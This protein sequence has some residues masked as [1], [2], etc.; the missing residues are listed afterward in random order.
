M[1]RDAYSHLA[2]VGYRQFEPAA[3]LRPFVQCYW[4]IQ[5]DGRLHAVREEFLHPDGATGIMFHVGDTPFFN[6]EAST[7]TA[8]INGPQTVT[9]RLGLRG[10]VETIGVRFRPG[11]A[12]ALLG[13]PLHEVSGMHLALD[14]V[15]TRPQVR[16]VHEQLYHADTVAAKIGIVERWLLGLL[17]DPNAVHAVVD[18][19]LGAI[20]RE[21][22]QVAIQQL[23]DDLH[24]SPRQ[25][26][27]LYK[28]HVG[29][30]PKQY[31]R[32][33][34]VE[35]ARALMKQNVRTIAAAP[36]R[37]DETLNTVDIGYIAG[38]YDQAH[39]IREFKAIEGITPQT[40]LEGALRRYS[41]R[42]NDEDMT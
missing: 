18:R 7:Q 6:G 30:S 10:A 13:A 39:F 27:R 21:R 37:N 24:I 29:L 33:V 22:G 17:A 40:Y 20:R 34:R 42:R 23:A 12:Y 1:T 2:Y 25:L 41:P 35:T 5:R 28:T 15:A 19:S 4:I 31:A 3:S 32:L 9:T 11:G 8:V 38:F 26:E 14:D 16:D 36:F